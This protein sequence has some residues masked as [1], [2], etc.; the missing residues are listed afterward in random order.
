MA[1]GALVVPAAL[2]AGHGAG[3]GGAGMTDPI[4]YV[5]VWCMGVCGNRA[6]SESDRL[7][8]YSTQRTEPLC[9]PRCGWDVVCVPVHRSVLARE[10]RG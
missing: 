2:G 8:G 7:P 6:P 9:C 4:A 3:A 5:R 1:V 10:G